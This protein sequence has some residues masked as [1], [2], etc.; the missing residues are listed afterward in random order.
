MKLSLNCRRILFYIIFY[1][2]LLCIFLV[3]MYLVKQVAHYLPQIDE[4]DL[5]IENYDAA[6][7]S[8]VTLVTGPPQPITTNGVQSSLFNASSDYN[9]IMNTV[10][11]Q[12][13]QQR[14]LESQISKTSNA[15]QDASGSTT[16]AASSSSS[17]SS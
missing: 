7:A 13:N 6:D 15:P 17:S 1:G 16:T 11:D 10:I 8:G 2:S 3:E 5:I 12:I 4:K 14:V 9:T